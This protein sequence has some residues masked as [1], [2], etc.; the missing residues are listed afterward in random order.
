MNYV[1]YDR[2][3]TKMVRTMRNGY[4]QDAIYK[5]L[6]AAKA[7]WTRLAKAGKILGLVHCINS[8]DEF[9]KIEKTETKVNLMSGKEFTQ[10]VNTPFCCDPSSET[11]WSM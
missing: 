4:R 9:R 2:L 7:A 5:T 8:M 1:I 6:P 11:Y 3:T 10:S